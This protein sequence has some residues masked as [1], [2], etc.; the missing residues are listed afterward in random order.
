MP[1]G[2]SRAATSLGAADSLLPLHPACPPCSL[3][4]GLEEKP[5]Y[6]S[7]LANV[8]D[9]PADGEYGAR[10]RLLGKTGHPALFSAAPTFLRA[11]AS[12]RAPAAKASRNAAATK[13]AGTNA[14]ALDFDPIASSKVLAARRASALAANPAAALALAGA[15]AAGPQA[16]GGSHHH[17]GARRAADEDEA[18]AIRDF[19]HNEKRSVGSA[20]GSVR[21]RFMAL[22]E[23]GKM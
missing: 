7:Q 16:L 23:Q 14:K 11:G 1:L 5:Y 13:A 10:R 4:S 19:V 6:G 20:H 12:A 17:S 15:G 22:K 2:Q 21:E 3:P 9:D 18:N 8:D